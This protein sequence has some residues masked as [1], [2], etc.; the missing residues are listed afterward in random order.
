VVAKLEIGCGERP[1]PGYVH[2][3]INPF[4]GV[5]LVC[6]PWEIDLAANSLEEALALG[7]IEHLTYWQ[8]EQ[9]IINVHRMLRPGGEFYFDVPDLPV[10]C[11]Y[12]VDHFNGRPAPFSIEHILSTLYGWQRWP[13]DEHKS[14]WYQEKLVATLALAGFQTARFGVD[15]FRA[16]GFERNRMKNPDDA[17]IYCVAVKD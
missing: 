12:A 16:R 10:W 4:D 2:N 5:E 9:T 11:A 13:G 8:V 15:H 7:V 1:T 17:H 6:N 14:G 3:D